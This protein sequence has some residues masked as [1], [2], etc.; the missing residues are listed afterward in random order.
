MVEGLIA[1]EQFGPNC[2][3]V[4]CCPLTVIVPVR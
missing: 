2:V 4:Y 1:N 3:M